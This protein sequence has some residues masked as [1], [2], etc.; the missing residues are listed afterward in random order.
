MSCGI[1]QQ[2]T[3]NIL[4]ETSSKFT[5]VSSNTIEYISCFIK[6]YTYRLRH[7]LMVWF[8]AVKENKLLMYQKYFLY[9]GNFRS[10][11]LTLWSKYS[12][13]SSN[14]SKRKSPNFMIAL[15]SL[16][17]VFSYSKLFIILISLIIIFYQS[18]F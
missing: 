13:C 12:S 10:S 14:E 9:K 15:K 17:Y 6:V 1:S 8:H 2:S 16:S 4:S 18:V 5:C 7:W 11:R 3:E